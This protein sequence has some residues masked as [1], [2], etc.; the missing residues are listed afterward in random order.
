MGKASRRDRREAARLAARVDRQASLMQE[1]LRCMAAGDIDRA[2]ELFA[3]ACP[4]QFDMFA[5]CYGIG[6]AIAATTRAQYP[7]LPANEP[8]CVELDVEEGSDPVETHVIQDVCAFIA[9]AGNHDSE[10]AMMV[11]DSAMSS[12]EHH[13]GGFVGHLLSI[14][15]AISEAGA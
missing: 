15:A 11:M 4:T 12:D 5:A 1:V 13:A 2:N 8:V 10:G 14:G 3:L 7:D 6:Y 9:A